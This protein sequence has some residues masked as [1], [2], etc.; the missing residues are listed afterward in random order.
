MAGDSTIILTNPHW[1]PKLESYISVRKSTEK[2]IFIGKVMKYVWNNTALIIKLSANREYSNYIDPAINDEKLLGDDN[3]NHGFLLVLP[4]YEWQYLNKSSSFPNMQATQADLTLGNIYRTAEEIEELEGLREKGCDIGDGFPDQPI[5]DNTGSIDANTFFKESDVNK[6]LSSGDFT[7]SPPSS[8]MMCELMEELNKPINVPL[9]QQKIIVNKTIAL[10]NLI[11]NK[12]DELNEGRKI[13]KWVV[14]NIIMDA[15]KPDVFTDLRMSVHNGYVHIARKGLPVIDKI[16]PELVP[17]L[18]FFKWQYNVPIDYDTLKYVLFQNPVQKT[19]QKNVQ[20]Q[21][22]AERIL[23]QE[24]LIGLQPE[25]KYQLWCLKRLIT[26]W[27]ADVDLQNNIRKIK[28]LINQWRSRED[29]EF[30]KK[31]GVLPS[32]VVYPKY[33]KNSARLVLLRLGTFFLYYNNLGWECSKPT[34]FI[35]LNNILWYTNGV[36]D[37]KLYFKKVKKAYVKNKNTEDIIEN[38]S[39]VERYTL[40]R[41][42]EKIIYDPK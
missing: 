6:I 39:F 24:Y 25:P 33:G 2:T 12:E 36:L 38:D 16:T 23:S 34:Y 1:P 5:L 22:E 3:D 9:T 8:D 35:K 30:N 10:R 19:I 31:Y 21:H 20:E 28:V 41:G 27:Y 40:I 37:L 7:F 13:I 14:D 15:T 32:I 26:C 18:I 42:A 29:V 4:T 17:K 11:T